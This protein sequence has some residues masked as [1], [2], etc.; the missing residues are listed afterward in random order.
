[1]AT[2]TTDKSYCV[3]CPKQKNI[4]KCEGCARNFCPTHA[5]EHQQE[6]SLQLGQTEDRYNQ[7][8]DTLQ[9][10]DA[11]LNQHPLMK[12]INEWEKES[13]DKIRRLALEV[14]LQASTHI[15]QSTADLTLQ[16]KRVTEKISLCRKEDDF[17][18]KEVQFFDAELRRLKDI[19]DTPSS[20]QLEYISSS[21]ISR[22]QLMNQGN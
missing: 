19:L 21:F 10:Q 5:I 12:Q 3:K 15:K 11:V 20:Q 17:A 22:I 1:M 7:F 14:R 4:S 13:M 8:H 9:H 2:G 18:D 16:F 6:L